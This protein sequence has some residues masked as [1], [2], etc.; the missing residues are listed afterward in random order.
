MKDRDFD[1]GTGRPR[2]WAAVV[3]LALG[4][5][6]RVGG[7][8]PRGAAGTAAGVCAGGGRGAGRDPGRRGEAD[9]ARHHSL[10]PPRL[11]RGGPLQ[12]RDRRPRG[13]PAH[14]HAHRGGAA[15]RDPC[16]DGGRG[17]LRR[18]KADRRPRN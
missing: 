6:T 8:A 5:L 11:L 4:A 2:H 15:R 16:G 3:L 17:G 18:L 9:P 1:D 10:E 13:G 7:Q 14:A 12:R